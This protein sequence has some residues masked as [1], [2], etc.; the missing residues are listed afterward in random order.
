M[1]FANITATPP[2]AAST[3]V[4]AKLCNLLASPA[5]VFDEVVITPPAAANWRT[6][7]LLVCLAGIVVLHLSPTQT[8]SADAIQHLIQAGT[9]STDQA[10]F[11]AG[12]WPLV[13]GLA[14]CLAAFGGTLWAAFV[15]WFM[16][17]VFLKARFSFLKALEVVGLTGIIL[18]L[19]NVVTGLLIIA[20]GDPT[21]HPSLALL[22]GKLDSSHVLRKILDLFHVFHLWATAVLA[23]GLSRLT[24]VTF[25]EAAFWVFGYWLLARIALVLL[26]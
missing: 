13:S 9:I 19:G 22:A 17:R 8:Q 23:V 24:G 2:R 11:L 5:E 12:A 26:A 4:S 6:P 3:S 21:A 18:L 16:G 10:E 1:N 7:T 25:R 15:L 20:T 14:V